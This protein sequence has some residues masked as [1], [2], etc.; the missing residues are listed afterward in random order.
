MQNANLFN[1]AEGRRLKAI[2]M[3]AASAW[4]YAQPVAIARNIALM[5]AKKNGQV[6]ADD[7]Y[8]WMEN[9]PNQEVIGPALEEIKKN[10]N[11]MG[12][13]FQTPRLKFSG[14]IT[15]SKRPERH[16]SMLRIWE[17]A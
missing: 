2:G 17:S 8:E 14:R 12:S 13:I 11:C 5:L 7:I 15:E 16:A 3:D 6:T 9:A 4:P 1:H 10:P